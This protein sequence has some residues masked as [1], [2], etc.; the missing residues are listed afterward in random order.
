MQRDFIEIMSAALSC[1]EAGGL[2]PSAY[3]VVI[4]TGAAPVKRHNEP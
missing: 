4:A 1:A 2:M 3:V